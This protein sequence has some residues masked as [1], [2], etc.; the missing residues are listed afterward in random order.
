MTLFTAGK[1]TI[2]TARPR[3]NV[4]R[5]VFLPLLTVSA[6]VGLDPGKRPLFVL[7]RGKGLHVFCDRGDLPAKELRIREAM[8]AGFPYE[9]GK[10]RK[11]RVVY[12]VHM[13]LQDR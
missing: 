2:G 12:D 13:D 11:G 9:A 7:V 1:R 4:D 10:E 6:G 3:Q 5:G 8:V